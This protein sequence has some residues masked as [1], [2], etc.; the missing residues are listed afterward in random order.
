MGIATEETKL[1]KIDSLQVYARKNDADKPAELDAIDPDKSKIDA[2]AEKL[3]RRGY[4]VMR[5]RK[6]RAGK[7]RYLFKAIWAGAGQPPDDPF[8]GL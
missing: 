3:S 7:T 8:E 6:I 1:K 5:Q 2:I 4:G